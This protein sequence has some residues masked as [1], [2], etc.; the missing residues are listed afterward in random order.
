VPSSF[1]GPDTTLTPAKCFSGIPDSNNTTIL[2]AKACFE[3]KE[4]QKP[5]AIPLM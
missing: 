1:S 3:K 5:T 4:V 2:Q